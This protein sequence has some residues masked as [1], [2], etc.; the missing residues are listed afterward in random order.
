MGLQARLRTGRGGTGEDHSDSN[1]CFVQNICLC[2][3]VPQ[4]MFEEGPSLRG[5]H[6]H[7]I[8]ASAQIGS[9]GERPDCS[10]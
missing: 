5:K 7:K 9:D 6:M 8:L 4:S 10:C 3:T 2:L 1:H